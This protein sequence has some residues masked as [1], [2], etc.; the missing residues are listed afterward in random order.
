MES[1]IVFT[2]E[3]LDLIKKTCVPKAADQEHFDLFIYT[4]QKYGLDPLTK[5]IVLDIRTN[6]DNGEKKAVIITTRDG[7]LK[8]A[9][10]TPDY[11]G[12][13]G[14]VIREGDTY[15]VDPINGILKHVF[16]S[17][18]NKIV[19]AWA[20]AKAKNRDPVI[21]TADFDEYSKANQ[22]SYTWKDYPSAMIQKVAEIM[23]MKRQ[24]NITGMVG[25]EEISAGLVDIDV[26][27]A[28]PPIVNSDTPTESTE[29]ASNTKPQKLPRK[30]QEKHKEKDGDK[31]IK[32]SQAHSAGTIS[33]D[34]NA[35]ISGDPSDTPSENEITL[36][37]IISEKDQVEENGKYKVKATVLEPSEIMEMTPVVLL[38]SSQTYAH[39]AAL[40]VKGVLNEGVFTVSTAN[41]LSGGEQNTQQPETEKPADLKQDTDNLIKTVTLRS[42]PVIGRLVYKGNQIDKLWAYT[43]DKTVVIGDCLRGLSSGAIIKIDVFDNVV[44][45]NGIMQLFITAATA[46]E[47]A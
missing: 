38:V 10:Q 13:N 37:V 47:V 18:R 43:E 20:V 46:V 19:A 36:V 11:N 8:A 28:T 44:T 34:S 40:E 30:E 42:D 9:M 14:G 3:Q 5:E 31:P 16:G 26:E 6:K 41:L 32:D 29:K 1:K 23:A 22:K 4:C 15:E 33:T 39:G 27:S 2:S 35:S 12:V 7:Y 21:C 45:E 25:E 24:F 17:K